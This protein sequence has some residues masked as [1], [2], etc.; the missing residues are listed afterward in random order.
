MF[1]TIGNKIIDTPVEKI[2]Y[3]V[4]SELNNGKLKDIV[5][6]GDNLAV[7]CPIH[8]DGRESNPSCYVFTNYEDE[9][10][11]AGLTHCFTCGYNARLPKLISDLFGMDAKFGEDWLI[12]R[13]CNIFVQ[14]RTIL[15]EFE[16]REKIRNDELDTSILKNFNFYHPYMWE[17]KLSKEVVDR[18]EV[19][20]D[21]TT[22][23]ITF[24]VY[25]EK[26]RLVM[27]TSRSVKTK[28][29][30]IPDEVEKP[31]YLLYDILER[32]ITR[33][34]VC[35]SQINT[36]YMRSLGYDSVGLFGT[37]SK[38]QLDTLKGSGIREYVLCFDGDSA[39]RLGASRFK[40]M[41]GKD[42]FITDI[43]LPWGKDINDLSRDEVEKLLKTS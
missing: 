24:P 9:E 2:L 42:V 22:Q 31:V 16:K 43:L 34:Y 38:T 10:R 3:D 17:R 5:R 21:E 1:L 4:R 6:K 12:E 26:R 27:V 11:E 29:F 14:K 41:I 35:E 7:T 8:K 28:R 23:S 15:P 39:G 32:G 13:Y 20:Y 18:F 25:D 33:V 37:G 30:H 40:R 19:G 36:L